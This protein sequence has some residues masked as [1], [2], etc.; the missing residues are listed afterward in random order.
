[1]RVAYVCRALA[2]DRLA[3][4]GAEVYSLACA[5]ARA[6]HSVHLVCEALP[7][8]RA[9]P[10]GPVHVPLAAPRPDPRYPAESLSYADRVYDTL[11]AL[12]RATP[13][14]VVEFVD[15]A[16]EGFT[17]IRARRLLGEFAGVRLVVA[18]HPWDR[19]A[20]AGP[21]ASP[22]FPR[23]VPRACCPPGRGAR[24][25]WP[26]WPWRWGWASSRSPAAPVPGWSPRAAARSYRP[27]T[28]PRS[29]RRY[30][31][32]RPRRHPAPIPCR[33]SPP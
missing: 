10:R 9:Q 11:R 22:R 16:G 4:G 5:A 30:G 31:R 27:T 19:P 8:Y 26:A 23:G 20:A 32:P 1:M 28:R 25:R 17:V 12:H 2:D 14:D 3:G 21:P 24:R 33:R 7:G 15:T 6:G 29:R 13:L 18:A